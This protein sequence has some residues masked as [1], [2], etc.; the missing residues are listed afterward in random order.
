MQIR[1]VC[2]GTAIA[3]DIASKPEADWLVQE[4]TKALGRRA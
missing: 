4:I 1:E 3:A 2:R